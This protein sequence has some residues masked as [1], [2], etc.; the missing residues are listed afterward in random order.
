MH[1]LCQLVLCPLSIGVLGFLCQGEL[2]Y[3]QN[4][5]PPNL[6]PLT[7]SIFPTPNDALRHHL[8]PTGKPCL[9]LAAHAQAQ[10]LNPH[11]FEHWIDATNTCG[12]DIKVQVCYFGTEDCIAMDVPPYGRKNAVLGIYPA[13][14]DFRY[15]AKE[16]F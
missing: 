6:R 2:A 11:I 3:G 13:M 9:S 10:T 15:E 4:L 7:G 12:Q 5:P 16:K 1:K 14:T 8:G